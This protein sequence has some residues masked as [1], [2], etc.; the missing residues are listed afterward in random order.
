MPEL[1]REGARLC[2]E[3]CRIAQEQDGRRRFVVGALGPTNRT[4]SI[5][6]DVN[7]PGFRAVSFD[8]L[9]DAYVEA[10]RALIEGGA[11]LIIIETIFDTLNAK[12]AFAG[13]ETVFAEIGRAA[14]DD[15]RHHHRSVRPHAVGPDAD[16]VLALDAAT[17]AVLDRPQLRARR[18]RDARPSGGDSRASPTRSSAPTRMPACPTSSA[19]TTRARSTWPGSSASSPKRASSTSSA[20]AAAPRRTTSAPSPRRVEGH[21]AARRP[22]VAPMLRLSGLEPFVLTTD[23]RFVNVGERTNV[24]GSARFRK[25]IKEGD[26]AAALDVAR[27]QVANGAQIIDIN[28]DE[29]LLDSRGRHGRVPQP[30]SPPSPTSPACR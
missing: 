25:L 21:R 9:H 16:G 10:T 17:R 7:N 19:S 28:M 15:L 23:I 12:A 14:G 26:L 18:A 4:A 30:R 27:D 22:D 13:V 3:A 24:T 29:G 6:P 11:D 20:A 1:N 5:S 2:R 8:E